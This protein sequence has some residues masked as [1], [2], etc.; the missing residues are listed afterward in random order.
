[1]SAPR[2]KEVYTQF[3]SEMGLTFPELDKSAEK[4]LKKSALD[5]PTKPAT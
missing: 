1:M 3:L 5:L 2:F 4:A